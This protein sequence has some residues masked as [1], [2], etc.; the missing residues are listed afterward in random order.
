MT[1][2]ALK[3]QLAPDVT[4][5]GNQI[6]KRR[7]RPHGAYSPLTRWLRPQIAKFKRQQYTC[8]N[9][10]YSLAETEE[11]ESEDAF[12]VTDETADLYY[13]DCFGDIRG[14]RVTWE[15]FRKLWQRT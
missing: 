3:P 7:G 6:S 9:V 11:K 12:I 10:F 13:E 14:E 4:Q 2:V 5:A 15:A 8:R 1:S